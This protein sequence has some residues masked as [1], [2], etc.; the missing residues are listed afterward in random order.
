MHGAL[1]CIMVN[2]T[3]VLFKSAYEQLIDKG[4]FGLTHWTKQCAG[5]RFV[6]PKTKQLCTL[7]LFSFTNSWF[8]QLSSHCLRFAT[9]VNTLQCSVVTILNHIFYNSGET[10]QVMSSRNLSSIVISSPVD[11]ELGQTKARLNS[12]YTLLSIPVSSLSLTWVDSIFE[13]WETIHG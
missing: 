10:S 1:T 3:N 5:S 9:T 8:Y 6:Q 11:I 2:R 12:T 13:V 4:T 7:L